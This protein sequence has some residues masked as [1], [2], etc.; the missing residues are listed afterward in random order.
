MQ[1]I[2]LLQLMETFKILNNNRGKNA[3]FPIYFKEYY[4]SMFMSEVRLG[5]MWSKL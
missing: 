4:Q 5:K 1:F 2:H 3:V